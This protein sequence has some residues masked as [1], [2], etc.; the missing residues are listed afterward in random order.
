[1]QTEIEVDFHQLKLRY[2]VYIKFVI[3][4]ERLELYR[5]HLLFSYRA[6]QNNLDTIAAILSK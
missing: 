1:M 2:Y 3:Q 5:K 6:T 4:N